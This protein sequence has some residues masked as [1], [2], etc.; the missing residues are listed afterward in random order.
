MIAR[1][2]QNEP[3]GGICV[4]KLTFPLLIE[5]PLEKIKGWISCHL[6]C[7]IVIF[8]NAK[9][10]WRNANECIVTTHACI[11]KVLLV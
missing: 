4:Q 3:N 9:W 6:K 11:G 2:D 5:S 10:L 7:C 1:E 8:N